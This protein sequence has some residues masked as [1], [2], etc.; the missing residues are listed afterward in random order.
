MRQRIYFYPDAPLLKYQ[1]TML[2][3]GK[4]AVLNVFIAFSLSIALKLL[5]N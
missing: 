1:R 4:A 5:Y 2:L 3:S